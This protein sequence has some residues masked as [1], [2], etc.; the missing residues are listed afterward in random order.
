[1]SVKVVWRQPQS[2]HYRRYTNPARYPYLVTWG[3]PLLTTPAKM[4]TVWGAF[5]VAWLW[6]MAGRGYITIVRRGPASQGHDT[7]R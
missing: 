1:M 7:G 6:R 5:L 3:N 4:R 2:R